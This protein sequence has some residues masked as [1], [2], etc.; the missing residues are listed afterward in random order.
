[1]EHTVSK[2]REI[3]FVG[4]L[5]FE[6]NVKAVRMIFSVVEKLS[7]VRGDF[8]VLIVG[9]P[10]E[11]VR[12][13]LHHDLV[14]KNLVKFLGSV[15]TKILNGF[16]SRA[17][18][19]LLP[20]F[21]LPR[22]GGQMMKTLKLMSYGLCIVGSPEAVKW[23]RGVEP[24]IHYVPV[25]TVEECVEVLN[26]LLDNIEE[27]VNIGLRARSLVMAKHTWSAVCEDYIRIIKKIIGD[28]EN[29]RLD[30]VLGGCKWRGKC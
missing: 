18:I 26:E 20:F 2:R 25:N 9:S 16:L 17:A 30:S 1:M 6:Q 4:N 14:N 3:L 28:P 22:W 24:R 19:A 13:L 8:R 12:D 10:L 15:P 23:I 11:N 27:C 5:G 21:K 29:I 7:R